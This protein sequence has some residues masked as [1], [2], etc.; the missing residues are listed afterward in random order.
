PK[1]GTALASVRMRRSRE[2]TGSRRMLRKS[3]TQGRRLRIWWR[4]L[5]GI[6][7]GDCRVVRCTNFVAIVRAVG[8]KTYPG[9]SMVKRFV[10]L[11]AAAVLPVLGRAEIT[12]YPATFQ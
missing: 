11:I 7:R 5:T 1:S 2:S 10:A 3:I 9:D 4:F 6:C 8:P 12:P